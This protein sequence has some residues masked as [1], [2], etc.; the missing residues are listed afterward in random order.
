LNMQLTFTWHACFCTPVTP[1]AAAVSDCTTCRKRK[2]MRFYVQAYYPAFV[3]WV[4][5][6]HNTPFCWQNY[7]FCR[8][9][10]HG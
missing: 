9:P 4:W 3:L 10:A 7:F 2:Y 5:Q 6:N 8:V 1:A